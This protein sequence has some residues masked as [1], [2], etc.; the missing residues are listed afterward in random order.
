[1]SQPLGLGLRK[2]LLPGLQASPSSGKPRARLRLAPASYLTRLPD[3]QRSPRLASWTP[4]ISALANLA[5]RG[6]REQS[7]SF[8]RFLASGWAGLWC[9]DD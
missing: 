8:Q 3:L 7:R 1:M 9:P 2:G 5:P 6:L 4:R